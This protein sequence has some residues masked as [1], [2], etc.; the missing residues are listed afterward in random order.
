MGV[1]FALL[2]AGRDIQRQT[3][4]TV[5]FGSHGSTPRPKIGAI[6]WALGQFGSRAVINSPFANARRM[7]SGRAPIVPAVSQRHI[8]PSPSILPQRPADAMVPHKRV[9]FV[10]VFTKRDWFSLRYR[11]NDDKARQFVVR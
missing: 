2:K 3:D 7:R 1:V 11:A 6:C 9:T 8:V 5:D 4:R 10:K